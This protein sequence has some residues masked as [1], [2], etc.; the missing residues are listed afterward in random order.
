M[1]GR[2]ISGRSRHRQYAR[3][4]SHEQCESRLCLTEVAFISHE[5]VPS[6]VG[7]PRSVYAADL[8]GDA[9]TQ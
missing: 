7:G 1:T 4:L 9:A 3:V 6:E 8:G 5:I 2:S